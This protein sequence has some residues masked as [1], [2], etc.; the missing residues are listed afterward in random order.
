MVSV[1][2]C[3]AEMSSRWRR[4]MDARRSVRELAV[5]P[6]EELRRIARDVGISA[7]ALRCAGGAHPGP[8]EL[9]PLRLQQLGMDPGFV[10]HSQTA[11]YRDLER[12]CATCNSWRRCA[13]DL[14]RGGVQ[15]G[16]ESY[17]PNAPTIDAL[18]LDRPVEIAR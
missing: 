3:V 12:V 8:S 16:M 2:L 13:R 6:P 11:A 10:K 5:C 4:L 1:R 7:A 9:L 14:R 15:A 17:C 18:T